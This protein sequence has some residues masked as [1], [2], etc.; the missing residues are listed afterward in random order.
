MTLIILLIS[1]GVLEYVMKRPEKSGPP[2]RRTD[3]ADESIAT[4]APSLA[5][6]GRALDQ[7]GRGSAPG[8]SPDRETT[9]LGLGSQDHV[10]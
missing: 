4:V 7:F 8:S 6:L 9:H 3:T 10:I 2:A 5:N 1:I